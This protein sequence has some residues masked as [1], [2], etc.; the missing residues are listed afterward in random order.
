MELVGDIEVKTG[1]FARQ[2][3]HWIFLA[4]VGA[5]ACSAMSPANSAA[6]VILYAST[7]PTVFE[8]STE[9]QLDLVRAG[10]N[11][12]Q[13]RR[14]KQLT[15][16]LAGIR[17]AKVDATGARLALGGTPVGSFSFYGFENAAPRTLS[18]LLPP[19]AASFSPPPATLGL[20]VLLLD[21][22]SGSLSIDSFRIVCLKA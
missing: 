12:L 18:F 17:A 13:G 20:R 1:V 10:A 4:A 9:T 7:S 2:I 5:A 3:Y 16:V 21:H 19:T 22:Q 6:D 8:G 14:C 15:L 11:A